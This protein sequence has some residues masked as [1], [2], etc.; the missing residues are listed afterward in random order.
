LVATQG[1]AHVM[2]LDQSE[3]WPILIHYNKESNILAG[4]RTGKKFRLGDKIKSKIL[5]VIPEEGKITL[6]PLI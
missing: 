6:K 2:I 3:N 1:L 4:R 5:N